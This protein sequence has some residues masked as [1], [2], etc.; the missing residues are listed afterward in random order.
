V[1]AG[2]LAHHVVAVDEVGHGD[3]LS[4]LGERPKARPLGTQYMVVG[5]E[6][7]VVASRI[8]N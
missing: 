8:P 1:P 2:R 6:T 4:S 7:D 3:D 5:A